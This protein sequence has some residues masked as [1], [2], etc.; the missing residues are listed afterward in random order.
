MATFRLVLRFTNYRGERSFTEQFYLDLSSFANV[1]AIPNNV[2]QNIANARCLALAGL[3]LLPFVRVNEV[4]T[5]KIV[6]NFD[7]NQIGVLGGMLNPD[8]QDVV[9][10][11]R[12][13]RV[14]SANGAKMNYLQ[15]G[16]ADGDVVAGKLTFDQNGPG[17]Y[18]DWLAYLKTRPLQ[19]RSSVFSAPK[20]INSIVPGVIAFSDPTATYAPGTTLNIRTVV[21]G[22][23]PKINVRVKVTASVPGSVNVARW[24]WGNCTGGNARAIDYTYSN[25]ISAVAVDN[26]ARTRKTGGPFS[27]FRGRRSSR[28]QSV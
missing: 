3:N 4:N 8:A 18:N 6:R 26:T 16:V 5:P 25:I 21:V 28:R 20:T 7:T 1:A 13:S 10:I 22:P 11:A 15:R 9:N 17:P 24:I 14:T 12:M 19:L 2:I 23:G 27:R